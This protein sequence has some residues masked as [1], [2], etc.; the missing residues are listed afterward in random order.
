EVGMQNSVI[1]R[2]MIQGQ[3]VEGVE[4]VGSRFSGISLHL[5]DEGN[6]P[7]IKPAVLRATRKMRNKQRFLDALNSNIDREMLELELR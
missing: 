6:E 4:P 2:R 3:L 1:R 7:I 5:L